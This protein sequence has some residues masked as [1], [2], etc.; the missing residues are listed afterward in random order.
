AGGRRCQR[1]LVDIPV[2]TV[3]QAGVPAAEY[4]RRLNSWE[5]R[6]QQLQPYEQYMGSVRLVLA[7]LIIATAWASLASRLFSALWILPAIVVFAAA[8]MVHAQLRRRWTR[9]QRALGLYRN[10]LA[11][12]Q[13]RW[14]G[15]G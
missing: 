8:V 13:D 12:L 15:S 10:G 6:A 9:A 5:A 4:T 1:R 7:A 14:A 3:S 11:R 2:Q